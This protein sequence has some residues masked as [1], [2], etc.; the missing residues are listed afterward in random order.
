M[1]QVAALWRGKGERLRFEGI[2]CPHCGSISLSG[3]PCCRSWETPSFSVG[4]A[5]A[6]LGAAGVEEIVAK[7]GYKVDLDTI[8]RVLQNFKEGR[9]RIDSLGLMVEGAIGGEKSLLLC[10]ERKGF[11]FV[12]REEGNLTV[13]LGCVNPA[14]SLEDQ[15]KE[16]VAREVLDPG[17]DA[18]DCFSVSSIRFLGKI[19]IVNFRVPFYS[20]RLREDAQIESF[21]EKRVRGHI[22]VPQSQALNFLEEQQEE[23]GIRIG[24]EEAISRLWLGWKF[25]D[26]FVCIQSE[27]NRT[28][29]RVLGTS[30]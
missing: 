21:N 2:A 19:E 16:L 20:L 6:S 7:L 27:F 29:T 12:G 10:Y 26:S 25:G 13:P 14:S 11:S 4:V 24:V 8:K 23:A 28:L 22:W 9:F 18:D 3:A 1:A 5:K 17:L 30:G 15:V